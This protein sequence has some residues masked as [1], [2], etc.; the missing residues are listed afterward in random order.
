MKA[1]VIIEICIQNLFNSLSNSNTMSQRTICLDTE[2]RKLRPAE[3]Y[4]LGQILSMSDSWKKL[5]AIVP[6]EGNPNLSKFNAEHF[7]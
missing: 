5:M 2:L 7:R 3:L 6:K 4:T 1:S